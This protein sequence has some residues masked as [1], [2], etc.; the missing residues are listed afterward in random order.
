MTI[1]NKTSLVGVAETI[2]SSSIS[3]PPL[4]LRW[5]KVI[6]FLKTGYEYKWC[7][8]LPVLN[9]KHLNIVHHSSSP[10]TT[11]EDLVTNGVA[12]RWLPISLSHWM[13]ESHT[14]ESP[15][16]QVKN[17]PLLWKHCGFG[18]LSLAAANVFY[19][20]QNSWLIIGYLH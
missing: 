4:Q 3:E 13:E 5:V 10:T 11:L 16:P 1:Q 7:K 6:G 9:F 18:G 20:D 12:T 15:H 17:Q 19:A 2:K 14:E 8:P